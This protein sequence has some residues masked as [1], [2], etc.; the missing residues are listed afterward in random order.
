VQNN[1]PSTLIAL[2]DHT[3]LP[4]GMAKLAATEREKLEQQLAELQS[5]RKELVKKKEFAT[6]K[7]LQTGILL[8]TYQA[9]LAAYHPDGTPKLLAMGVRDKP[10][11]CDSELFI[12]GE[13]EK[14]GPIVPR[15]FIEILCDQKVPEFKEKSGRLELANWI[16]S[17]SNPL[18][19]RVIVNRVWLNLFGQGMV[20]TPDNFGMS[21]QRPS[22]PELLDY[23]ALRFMEEGWSIKTLI[24]EIVMSRVYRL[25]NS[26][27][28]QNHEK[29]PDNI[30]L[31]RMSP[32]RL[33]ADAIRDAMLL[34]AGVLELTPPQGSVVAE[35]GEGYVAGLDRLGLLIEI[36]HRCRS[37]YLPTIRGRPFESLDV[38]DGVDGSL[39][40]GQREQTTDPA[41]SLY[42]LNSSYVQQLAISASG[43][44][45]E[46][47]S[48]HRTRVNQI[49][50]SFFGRS[51][52]EIE[53]SAA[54]EFMNRY[55]EE[56]QNNRVTNQRNRLSAPDTAAWG[57]FCQ[58][59]WA[60]SE[61]LVRK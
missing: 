10:T 39:V 41:Q 36:R 32:R 35:G 29:D 6:T 46:L 57:A 59:L 30:W 31:W 16:A 47:A 38:F 19:A 4:T 14:P 2:P 12:R 5:V 42:L 48:D 26:Y 37:V 21:G 33:D 9:K 22:H 53:Q 51:A 58:S 43:K 40:M 23:L 11:P 60:S 55:R 49:Y 61:F 54:I 7:F 50:L 18:T 34:T 17:E 20:T 24:R 8:S 56:L 1:N 44:F 25:D 28:E 3:K 27:L 13:V 52:S 15:G 45:K